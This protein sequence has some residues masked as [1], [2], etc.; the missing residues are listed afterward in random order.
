LGAMGRRHKKQDARVRARANPYER[1]D[2]LCRF[3]SIV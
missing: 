2:A 3:P 1:S